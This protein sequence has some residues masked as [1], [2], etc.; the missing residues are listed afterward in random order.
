MFL[1]FHVVHD[2]MGENISD[3]VINEIKVMGVSFTPDYITVVQE[4]SISNIT[5]TYSSETQVW[6]IK[7]YNLEFKTSNKWVTLR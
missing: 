7:E 4:S 2:G 1:Q 3:L 6:F 5:F